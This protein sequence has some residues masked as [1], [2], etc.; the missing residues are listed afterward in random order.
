MCSRVCARNPMRWQKFIK[1]WKNS[2]FYLW[3]TQTSLRYFRTQRQFWR[4]S[5][6]RSSWSAWG[7][8][9]PPS[10]P[11]PSKTTG[12]IEMDKERIIITIIVVSNCFKTSSHVHSGWRSTLPW[13]QKAPVGGWPG[14]WS[15]RHRCWVWSWGWRAWPPVEGDEV[16]HGGHAYGGLRVG[17]SEEE[18]LWVGAWLAAALYLVD[19][20]RRKVGM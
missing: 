15:L 13:T 3:K 8:Q 14:C 18:V 2:F 1:T 17:G 19:L 9:G 12:P 6:S 7:S 5:L 20:Q 10:C 11:A 4:A 16:W